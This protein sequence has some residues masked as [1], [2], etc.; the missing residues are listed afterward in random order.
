M[1][2]VLRE[3]SHDYPKSLALILNDWN[4]PKNLREG[5]RYPY[6]EK[7]ASEYIEAMM[8]AD[9]TATFAYAVCADGAVAGSIA[10]F[11]GEN[12]HFRTAEL[13]YYIDSRL[14][15]RGIMT[16]A[17]GMLCDKI[18]S[19]TDILRTY[20]EPFADNAGSRRVLEK[21]GFTLEGIMKSNA[22]KNG[23]VRDMA[24]D[25]PVRQNY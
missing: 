4:V 3:W 8:R 5:I 6:T 25:A 11:R 24:L 10:A 18:F 15:G 21:S 14:W 19:E 16:E 23:E 20:A 17:V 13:G 7:D 1:N 2:V 22:F 9:K 12:I